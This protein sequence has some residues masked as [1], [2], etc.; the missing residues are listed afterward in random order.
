MK[1]HIAAF[2]CAAAL[3]LSPLFA[4]PCL[5]LQPAPACRSNFITEFGYGYQATSPLKRT[6]GEAIDDSITNIYETQVTGRHYLTSELGYLYNLSPQYGLGFTHFTGWDPGHNLRGGLKLRMRRWLTPKISLEVS[7]GAYLWGIDDS[8]L[9]KPA[10]LGGASVNFS[11]W[12]AV[13]LRLEA[14]ETLPYDNTYYYDGKKYRSFSP[15]TRNLGVYLGYKLSS[16]PGLAFN[17]LAL[18]AVGVVFAVV[19]AVNAG[20]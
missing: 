1:N 7:A 8:E 5:R 16:R 3:S 2:A 15:R 19:L 20:D 17:G 6:F 12:E 14:L 9:K 13:Q 10:L 18:T 11:E 4:Q